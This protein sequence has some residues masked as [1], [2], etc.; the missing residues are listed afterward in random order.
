MMGVRLVFSQTAFR[1]VA[2]MLLA[3]FATACE[4]VY[5][6]NYIFTP[7]ESEQGKICVNQCEQIK[8][9]CYL[10]CKIESQACI[11]DAWREARIEYRE[12]VREMEEAGEDIVKTPD[13]FFNPMFCGEE[14]CASRCDNSHRACY[15]MC[16]GM[17]ESYTYCAANCE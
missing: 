16:G 17:V 2:V 10:N 9:T 5:R 3:V 12:Y 8:Q 7:P 4:P 15:P 13:D 14:S 6:T 1:L 11:Q